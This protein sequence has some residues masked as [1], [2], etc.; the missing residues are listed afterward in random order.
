MSDVFLGIGTNL[1]DRSLNLEIALGLL[2]YPIEG[3]QVV[4]VSSIIETD[5]VGGPSQPKFL[6]GVV[7]VRTTLPPYD[8][9]TYLK[10]IERQMGRVPTVRNGPRVIDLDIL[11]YDDIVMKSPELQIPHPRMFERPFVLK[12]LSDLVPIDEIKHIYARN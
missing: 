9:L 4:D 12:P 10:R 3:T 1:G 8:L 5:P 7:H 11:I 6:N 2:D